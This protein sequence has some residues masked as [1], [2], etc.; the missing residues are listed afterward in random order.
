MSDQPGQ[1]QQPRH[2]TRRRAWWPWILIPAFAVVGV[3]AGFIGA[4]IASPN[5]SSGSE[6]VNAVGNSAANSTAACQV[7]SVAD[8]VLPSVVTISASGQAG[9]GT[10]S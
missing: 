2:G 5:S 4:A 1:S 8:D 6:T 10:G 3:G 9:A 7:T